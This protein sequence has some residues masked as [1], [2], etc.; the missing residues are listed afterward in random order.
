[1]GKLLNGPRPRALGPRWGRARTWG[2]DIQPLEIISSVLV[3]AR[4]MVFTLFKN[5]SKMWNPRRVSKNGFQKWFGT[6]SKNK[7]WKVEED[8]VSNKEAYGAQKQALNI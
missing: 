4:N 5:V 6:I 8:L 2:Y 3:E 7:Y 1:M